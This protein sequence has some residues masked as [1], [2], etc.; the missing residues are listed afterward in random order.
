MGKNEE[1]TC[2]VIMPFGGS[3]KGERFRS[4]LIYDHVI[5]PAFDEAK[6]E[7]RKEEPA[8]DISAFRIDEAFVEDL[9]ASIAKNLRNAPI[10]VA[11]VSGNNANV[12]FELGFRNAH[13]KLLVC[14]SHR[15]EDAAFWAGKFQVIDYTQPGSQKLIAAGILSGFRKV[16]T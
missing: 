4:K 3:D 15:P 6:E 14:I 1:A 12:F 2:F 16:R 11:D 8:H 9:K 10:V 13:D 7:Y 5:R